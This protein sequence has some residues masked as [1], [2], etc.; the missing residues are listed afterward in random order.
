MPNY[1]RT[2]DLFGSTIYV[3]SRKEIGCI[4]ANDFVEMCA[5]L[6]DETGPLINLAL[7]LREG[8]A[9]IDVG[10]NVG[11]FSSVLSRASNVYPGI[12]TYAF[13]PNPETFSRLEKSLAGKNAELF[14]WGLSDANEEVV[15][16][17]GI[18]SGAF[19]PLVHSGK[20]QLLDRQHKIQCRR[21]DSFE[22]PSDSLVIKLDAEGHELKILAGARAL[23]EQHRVKAVLI[24]GCGTEAK[25]FL[26]A[27]NFLL[28]HGHSLETLPDSLPRCVL[29]V[30]R[31]FL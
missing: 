11:L 29:G 7:L 27:N 17:E 20:K 8:D 3:N 9:F 22:F 26:I 31:K 13:E 10:A 24:D 16:C 1:D 12:K 30:H 18:T 15:F 28:F 19:A 14:Q 5:L 25:D 6:R 2:V 21:L 23:F 4:R